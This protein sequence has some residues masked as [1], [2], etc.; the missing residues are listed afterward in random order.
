MSRSQ[1]DPSA[2]AKTNAIAIDVLQDIKRMEAR[3]FGWIGYP[4]PLTRR[5]GDAPWLVQ[6]QGLVPD[7][8]AALGDVENEDRI[9]D[10]GNGCAELTEKAHEDVCTA[11]SADT[12]T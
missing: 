12:D 3:G 5:V 2:V 7:D 11:N 10:S 9:I 4:R 6:P 1:D 8:P